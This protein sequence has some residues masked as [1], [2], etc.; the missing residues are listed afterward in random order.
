M[1]EHRPQLSRPL[2]F[3][4]QNL[5]IA[6]AYVL[7]ARVG[8]SLAFLNSQVSPIWPPEGIALAAL[9]LLG[10]SAVPGVLIGAVVANYLESPKVETATLIG[11]GN[12]LG[13]ILNASIVTRWVGANR[14][15]SSTSGLVRFLFGV[16]PGSALSALIGVTALW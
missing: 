14:I 3:I 8:F 2:V 11:L 5:A 12:T 7:G 1:T 6:L 13:A 15:L 16:I 10:R 9:L 4:G